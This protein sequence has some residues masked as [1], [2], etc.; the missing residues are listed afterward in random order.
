MLPR[1]SDV[2]PVQM[3]ILLA[4]SNGPDYGY[5]LM[6]R[7]AAMFSGYWIPKAGTIYPALEK[8]TDM[9]LVTRSQEHREEGL[10]RR[11]YSLTDRG[12]DVLYAGME[13]WSR[14]MEHVEEY[15]DRH[16]SIR[17]QF[18]E[19]TPMEAGKAMA[20][21]GESIS[22]GSFN[23]ADSI[24]GTEPLRVNLPAKVVYNL[25]YKRISPEEMEI[26]VEIEWKPEP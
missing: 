1:E 16:R 22:R 10:D 5:N 2:T 17:R 15:G 24:P 26:E 25:V 3:W 11:Y 6:Q 21:F 4:L 20:R 7:L 13:R 9:N 12:G 19:M 18:M 23:F 8:L 14:V